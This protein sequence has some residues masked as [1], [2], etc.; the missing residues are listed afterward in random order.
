MKIFSYWSNPRN[1][2]LLSKFC[3]QI[4]TFSPSTLKVEA[5]E[6]QLDKEHFLR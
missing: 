6:G 4:K 3:K 1:Q 5:E 2:T